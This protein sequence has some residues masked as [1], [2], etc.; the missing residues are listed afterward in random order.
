MNKKILLSVFCLC[1]T[2]I[3]AAGLYFSGGY[4]KTSSSMFY[5]TVSGDSKTDYKGIKNSVGGFPG[6]KPNSEGWMAEHFAAGLKEQHVYHIDKSKSF[7]VAVGW[8]I[9]KNPLRIEVEYEKLK[10][11]VSGFTMNIYDPNGKV[12]YGTV[13]PDTI[14]N[15][16][17]KPDGS[18]PSEPPFKPNPDAGKFKPSGEERLTSVY[19]FNMNFMKPFTFTADSIMAN[20]LFEIPILGPID[21]YVGFGVGK[22][23][24]KNMPTKDSDLAGVYEGSKGYVGATQYIAGIEARIPETPLIFGVEYKQLS[25]KFMEKDDNLPYTFDNKSFLFKVKYDFISNVI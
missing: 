4:G 23:L 16:A 10:S 11:S 2:D 20:V 18:T 24:V 1:A 25:S 17:Y 8:Q 14:P 19:E 12:K 9:P 6:G 15:P 13:E 21:P 7:S 3:Y 5:D 22:V